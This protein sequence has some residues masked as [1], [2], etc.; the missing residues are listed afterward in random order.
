VGTMS[1]QI[2]DFETIKVLRSNP[3]SD[4]RHIR[5]K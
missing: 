2:D 3:K 4:T 1:Q 5:F